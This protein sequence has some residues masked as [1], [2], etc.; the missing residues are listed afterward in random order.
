[1][2]QNA[3]VS[4][5]KTKLKCWGR[6]L[7]N[8]LFHICLMEQGGCGQ[9]HPAHC[10]RVGGD[11][12]FPRGLSTTT[13]RSHVTPCNNIRSG[14]NSSRS[15]SNSSSSGSNSRIVGHMWFQRFGRCPAGPKFHADSNS[16]CGNGV[17]RKKDQKARKKAAKLDLRFSGSTFHNKHNRNCADEQYV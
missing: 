13:K 4:N 11:Q 6:L 2:F 15:G 8:S 14:S 12:Q 16:G 5:I 9:W 3:T 1:M 7:G 17:R 10:A